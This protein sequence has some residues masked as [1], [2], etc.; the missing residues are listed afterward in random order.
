MAKY[1]DLDMNNWKEYDDILTDSLWIF[2]KRDKSG[3]H[4]ASYHGNFVPQIPNQLFKRYTKK[5]DWILDPFAGGGTSLIE[6]QRLGRN[7]IGIELQESVAKASVELLKQEKNPETQGTIIIGDSRSVNIA[8][9]IKPYGIEKVQF[10][11]YH[12]P[13]WDIIK[14]S[15]DEKDLSNCESLIDFAQAFGQVIDNTS[16]YLEKNRYCAC[17]IGD[18]YANSEIVPLGFHCMNLFLARGFKLKAILV[19]NFEDTKGKANQKAIWRYRALAS[20][21]YLFKHEYIFVFKK[22]KEM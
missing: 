17:V 18:K 16:Q 12:P 20:D 1:N 6:A 13:Y 5:G 7:S 10:V 22:V 8:E 2:D 15:E 3:V 9:K 4:N 19:K 21:F 11:I 14:F